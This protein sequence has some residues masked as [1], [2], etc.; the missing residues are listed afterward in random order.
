MFKRSSCVSQKQ[1]DAKPL[2]K[3]NRN[4][5]QYIGARSSTATMLIKFG[6]SICAEWP[7]VG[8]Y[9]LP[10]ADV[11]YKDLVADTI[12]HICLSNRHRM[13]R[14]WFPPDDNTRHSSKIDALGTC[15]YMFRFYQPQIHAF[16]NI[17]SLAS[18]QIWVRFFPYLTCFKHITRYIIDIV[19]TL[20]FEAYRDG[21]WLYTYT[22]IS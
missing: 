18:C 17:S 12:R 4:V 1:F 21:G 5:K 15:R 20:K 11:P 10:A 19:M 3:L 8:W 22:C 14:L 2:F 13:A 16:T 7:Q 9:M 6:C